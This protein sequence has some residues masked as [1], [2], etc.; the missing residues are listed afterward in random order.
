MSSSPGARSGIRR[1]CAAGT[2]PSRPERARANAYTLT[3]FDRRC[4]LIVKLTE[5]K[6]FVSEHGWVAKVMKCSLQRTPSCR[7]KLH[8]GSYDFSLESVLALK[9]VS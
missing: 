7:L 2:H 6:L 9:P 5:P 4:Q 3:A 1:D 8:D